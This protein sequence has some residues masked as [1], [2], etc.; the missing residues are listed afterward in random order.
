[1]KS[2]LYILLLISLIVYL[3]SCGGGT[4]ETGGTTAADTLRQEGE[5]VVTREQYISS[6]MTLARVDTADFYVSVHANGYIRALPQHR[7]AISPYQGGFVR[8]IRVLPGTSVRKG[9]VLMTLA[10]PDYVTLQQNYL[11]AKAQLMYLKKEYERQ[12]KL[13]AE[14]IASQ[15][16]LQKTESDYLTTLARY[17]SLKEQLR[18]L[19]ISP[20]GVEKSYFTSQ[21][22]LRSPIDGVVTSVN[23]VMGAFVSPEDVVVR[24]SDP[25]AIHL[26]LDVYENDV[27]KIKPGQKVL[28]HVPGQ[29]KKVYSGEI[30]L[31]TRNIDDKTRSVKILVRPDQ[32]DMPLLQGMYVEADIL[33]GRT[34]SPY[35]PE[36]AVVMEGERAV[37]LMKTGVR[38]GDLVFRKKEVKTGRTENGR[39]E[40]LNPQ[41]LGDR[42]VL[43]KGAFFLM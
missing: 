3:P 25:R 39:I 15:K 10:N 19:G 17:S 18:L 43:A 6:G 36:N 34:R 5:I 12:K 31:T 2:S 9:E 7:A 11:E 41:V 37:V 26:E 42:E 24:I 28:F 32:R 20:A 27:L 21:V 23:T 38:D 40:I 14:N 4:T 33:T 13:S 16:N 22:A 30:Y 29:A 35:L 1:M 8:N